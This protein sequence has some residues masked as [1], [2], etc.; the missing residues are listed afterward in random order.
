LKM[1]RFILSERVQA[2][3]R[4]LADPRAKRSFLNSFWSANDPDT[5]TVVCE[6]RQEYLRRIKVANE[7]FGQLN[8]EGW[9]TDRGRVMLMNGEPSFIEDHPFESS[10]GKAYQIW[11]YDQIEGGV[12]FVFVDRNNYGDY[13]QVHSNKK[14]E[15]YNPDWRRLELGL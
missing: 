10:T 15:L 3:I 2:Q 1:I 4:E 5:S 11:E 7:R 6:Y 14:G 9:T 8:R 13:I 12:R